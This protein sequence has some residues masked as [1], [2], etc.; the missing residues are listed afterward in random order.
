MTVAAAAVVEFGDRRCGE[1]ATS[2]VVT[3][4]TLP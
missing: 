2:Q 1:R 4:S 3:K